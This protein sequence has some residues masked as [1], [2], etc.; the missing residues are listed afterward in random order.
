MI[1]EVDT[2]NIADKQYYYITTFDKFEKQT[3]ANNM[4][5]SRWGEQVEL[6]KVQEAI[7]LKKFSLLKA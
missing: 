3:A 4:S 5:F 6:E 7:L 1:S 2:S